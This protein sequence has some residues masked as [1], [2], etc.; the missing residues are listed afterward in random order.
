MTEI[1]APVALVTGA[2]R[3]IG[4]A[5]V[6][7]LHAKGYR[8]VLHYHQSRQEAETLATTLN[9]I[10]PDSVITVSADLIL[11][12][13]LNDLIN[14][15][16]NHWGRL[17]VLVN[18]ASGYFST[19]VGKITEQQWDELFA[20]NAKAPFFLSQT[21]LPYL[22]KT[23][24]S[25]VN[26]IDIHSAHTYLNHSIYC[27]AKAALHSLTKNLAREFA[28]DIRVNGVSPGPSV[29]PEGENA[30]SK[31]KQVTIIERQP[32][33]RL[34]DLHDIAK[35]VVFFIENQSITGQILAVDG[36]RSLI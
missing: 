31:E 30:L 16:I 2:A 13:K 24:G 22:R 19:P 8:I 3:R 35:A 20:S 14:L 11:I 26:I 28:P 5:I 7:A 1:V 4:A 10:R 21:A 18:N 23:K 15:P 9:Q 34:A 27:S 33:K 36:G 6:K 29:W 12:S 17:D 25:I 32:L